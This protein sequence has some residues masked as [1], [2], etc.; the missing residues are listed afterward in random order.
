MMKQ[1]Q[2][3]TAYKRKIKAEQDMQSAQ[4]QVTKDIDQWITVSF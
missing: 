3:R 2:T 4:E 1:R